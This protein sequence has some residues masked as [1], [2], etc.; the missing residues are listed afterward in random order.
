MIPLPPVQTLSYAGIGIVALFALWKLRVEP[1]LRARG[2]L[3][4]PANV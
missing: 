3:A 2:L 1:Q 4:G